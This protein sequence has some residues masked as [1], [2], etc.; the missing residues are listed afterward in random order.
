[1]DVCTVGIQARRAGSHGIANQIRTYA[2][3][4]S[5]ATLAFPR[6]RRT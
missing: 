2:I 5:P 1:M 6:A 4:G 3:D